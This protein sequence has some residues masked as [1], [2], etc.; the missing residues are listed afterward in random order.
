MLA[1]VK[2]L[3]H[4]PIFSCD[5]ICSWHVV[6]LLNYSVGFQLCSQM[7]CDY[8]FKTKTWKCNHI[9][10]S[11]SS[12]DHRLPLGKKVRDGFPVVFFDKNIPVILHYFFFKVCLLRGW[13]SRRNMK[14]TS[15]GA[16]RGKLQGSL[17]VHCN[18]LWLIVN[19]HLE[20][21]LCLLG[22]WVTA[23]GVEG[24]E[25]GSEDWARQHSAPAEI[26]LKAGLSLTSSSHKLYFPD[27]SSL[28]PHCWKYQAPPACSSSGEFQW[29][30]LS[31]F[32]VT[33]FCIVTHNCRVG[34]YRKKSA[35]VKSKGAVGTYFRI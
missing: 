32:S 30:L 8:N 34:S 12:G 1:G 27:R 6:C 25:P 20:R 29:A 19:L 9:M 23:G 21:S 13:G 5:Q 22:V 16:E 33:V 31:D 3:S 15:W 18:T 2:V 4:F 7:A 17:C 26:L 35:L 14:H 28:V 11:K 10:L 24:H